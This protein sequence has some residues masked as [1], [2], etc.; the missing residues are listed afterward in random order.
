MN[1]LKVVLMF[2]A[3]IMIQTAILPNFGIFSSKANMS[4]ALVVAI[5]MN[6]GSY[7]S[8]YSGIVLGIIE[9]SLFSKVIG[10]RALIYYMIGFI[11]G[12]NEDSINK[13]DIRSG[14]IITVVATLFYWVMNTIIYM[15]LENSS[16]VGLIKYLK[17]PII[18]EMIL[19][20]IL[21]LICNY[22]IKKV[23]KKRKF[24]F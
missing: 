1:R 7:V 3:S 8:G 2:F 14:S 12:Y 15:F 17:G 11:V 22:V 10:I 20:V 6:F 23:F 5:A 4:L 24:R 13:G 16:S 9:D 19:N 18:I 21:Y